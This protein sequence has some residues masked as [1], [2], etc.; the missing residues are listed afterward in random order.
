MR[1]GKDPSYGKPGYFQYSNG[2]NKSAIYMQNHK[3][4]AMC[5][6]IRFRDIDA[7]GHVNNA[8]FLT[9]FEEGRKVFLSEVFGITEPGQYP[10]ILAR[11]SCDYLRPINLCDTVALHVW[12]SEI[13]NKSF[14]FAYEL[15][16]PDDNMSVYA[17]GSSVMVCY[18]YNEKKTIPISDSFKKKIIDY[19]ECT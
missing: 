4:I 3:K 5:V 11:I 14:T 17:N 2:F 10:F 9:Y 6:T 19:C 15:F 18:D 7:M 13:G 16:D 12:V 8:L 1:R